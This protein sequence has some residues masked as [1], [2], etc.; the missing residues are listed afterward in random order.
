MIGAV[1]AMAE[2]PAS[3]VAASAVMALYGARCLPAEPDDTR[4]GALGGCAP[5]EVAVTG[6]GSTPWSR[7][8]GEDGAASKGVTDGSNR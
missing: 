6:S 4:R 1:D 5:P 3:V 2:K 7:R 8:A